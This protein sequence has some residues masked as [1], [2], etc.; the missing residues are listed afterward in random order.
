MCILTFDVMFVV[1]FPA[2][3][4]NSTDA[5]FFDMLRAYNAD[6][7]DQRAPAPPGIQKVL[8]GESA[9]EASSSNSKHSTTIS[10]P[11]KQ[12]AMVQPMLPHHTNNNPYG[13]PSAALQQPS[14]GG[15]VNIPPGQFYQQQ[16]I[17][18]STPAA[19]SAQYS[20]PKSAMQNHQPHQQVG[21]T[22]VVACR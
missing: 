5:Q 11:V 14:A 2:G 4:D 6:N 8:R 3:Y 20:T 7:A 22:T 17:H 9:A 18:T 15:G 13:N 10:S 19:A 16:P 21:G 12:Q 1:F